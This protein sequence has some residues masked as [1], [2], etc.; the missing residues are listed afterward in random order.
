MLFQ[1]LF[2]CYFYTLHI[3]FQQLPASLLT[4]INCH[5]RITHTHTYTP[6]THT[7]THGNIITIML[8]EISIHCTPIVTDQ[9]IS[10]LH[11]ACSCPGFPGL[12]Y[13]V[14]LLRFLCCFISSTRPPTNSCS[15]SGSHSGFI[16]SLSPFLSLSPFY[17]L[18]AYGL[19][20]YV[21]Y[22]IMLINFLFR[23]F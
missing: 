15:I 17:L 8:S 21:T 1:V 2:R 13:M 23:F 20:L 11:S 7:H 3:S 5:C 22:V 10:I 4:I 14:R 16:S 19:P 9:S 18:Q 6:H 12:H